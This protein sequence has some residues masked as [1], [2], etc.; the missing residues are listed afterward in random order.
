MG[1]NLSMLFSHLKNN[2]VLIELDIEDMP[3]IKVEMSPA[4]FFRLVDAVITTA[5]PFIASVNKNIADG[6]VEDVKVEFNTEEWG[7]KMDGE[8]I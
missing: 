3:P 4:N 6:K 8:E 2:R 5:V 1:L 7:R